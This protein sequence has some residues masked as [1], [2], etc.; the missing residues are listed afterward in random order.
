MANNEAHVRIDE[1]VIRGPRRPPEPPPQRKLSVALK[2]LRFI[3]EEQ[4]AQ[5]A[6][7]T[8]DRYINGEQVA[9]IAPDY[10]ISDVTLYA[11]LLRQ[12]ESAWKDVQIAR[13]LARLETAQQGLED[14]PD[15]LSLARSRERV[16]SA[17]WE[18]ERLFSR[19]FGQK[20]EVTVIPTIPLDVMREIGLL[21]QEL[22][23]ALGKDAGSVIDVQ[24][25]AETPNA[26][27]LLPVQPTGHPD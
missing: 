24:P 10:G 14:A 18:L 13:A 19:L 21:R 25:V 1:G 22:G 16:R 9:A 5:I 20:Q 4:R 12:H 3:P 23:V 7:E 17:Q 6:E 8:L 11:L 27:L 2:P 26:A 15:A